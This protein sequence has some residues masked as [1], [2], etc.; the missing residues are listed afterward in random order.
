MEFRTDAVGAVAVGSRGTG[1]TGRAAPD[2][3]ALRWVH[4]GG[5]ALSAAHVRRWFD[6]FGDGQ[7]IANLYGPTETTINATCHIIATRPADEVQTLPIG[8]PVSGTDLLVVDADGARCRPGEP[9]ELLIAGIGLTPVTS[10][11]Q[12]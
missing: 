8:R 4:V 1:A 7:R 12:S 5:E 2:L 6:L 10:A 9:G 3:S 11:S